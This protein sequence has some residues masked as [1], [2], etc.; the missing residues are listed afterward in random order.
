MSAGGATLRAALAVSAAKVDI[1]V[2]EDVSLEQVVAKQDVIS[3]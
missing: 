1:F 3:V 2:G